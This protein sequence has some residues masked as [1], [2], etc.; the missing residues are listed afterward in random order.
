[1]RNKSIA[2]LSG[3]EVEGMGLRLSRLLGLWVRIPSVGKDVCLL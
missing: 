3:R 1:M 2:D